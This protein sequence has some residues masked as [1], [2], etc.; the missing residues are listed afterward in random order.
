M[1]NIKIKHRENG[2]NKC[3]STCGITMEQGME[4]IRNTYTDY[5]EKLTG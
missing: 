5:L 1:K 4:E 2:E 3:I